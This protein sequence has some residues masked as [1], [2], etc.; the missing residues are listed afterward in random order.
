MNQ[1]NIS[2]FQAL[3]PIKYARI[4]AII[5]FLIFSVLVVSSCKKSESEQNTD[6]TGKITIQ[7]VHKIDG[8]DIIFDTLNYVNAAGNP[9]LITE[10][11][12]FISN[13]VLYKDDGSDVKI[14]DWKDINYVDTNIP[15]TWK[16]EVYDNIPAGTYDSIAFIFGIPQDENISYMFVNPPERDM[17][18]PEFLG[19][20]YHYM[21]LN[22]KWLANGQTTETT[23]FDFHLGI[24]QIYYSYPD[25]IT[26]FVQNYF[27]V[28]LPG[29]GF[30]LTKGENKMI[31]LTM[32]VEKWFEEPN[33]FDFDVWGGYIMQNQEAMQVA[34]EN[35]FNVFTIDITE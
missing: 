31:R 17:F 11:Q 3:F 6:N 29:S 7:F 24:G 23:P 14:K 2:P 33:V 16:W 8:N 18:W 13:V 30:T 25:S 28:S 9:Y 35:G 21:K 1:V 26:S 15:S 19:G 27:R 5:S 22:G 4:F 12:Y 34:K 10:I 20:G 32:N